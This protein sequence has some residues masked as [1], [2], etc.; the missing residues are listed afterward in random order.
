MKPKKPNSAQRQV[1]RVKITSTNR[2]V[3]VSIPGKGHTLQQFSNVL[4]RG[5]RVRD[6]PGIHYRVVRG[7]KDAKAVPDTTRKQRRSK[8]GVPRPAHVAIE[9]DFMKNQKKKSLIKNGIHKFK[10]PLVF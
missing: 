2:W 9:K 6:L 4:I 10:H 1:A 3:T 5:G 8:F 7:T